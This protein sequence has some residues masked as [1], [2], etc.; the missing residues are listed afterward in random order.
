M[1]HALF[2]FI[3]PSDTYPIFS[4]ISVGQDARKYAE[5]NGLFFMETSAKTAINVNDIF[6]EIG[7]NL[8]FF[9]MEFRRVKYA[10]ILTIDCV[11]KLNIRHLDLENSLELTPL[12]IKSLQS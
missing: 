9:Y 8:N 4:M 1:L 2:R 3:L 7:R 6:Y 11:I 10:N 12:G 5:D